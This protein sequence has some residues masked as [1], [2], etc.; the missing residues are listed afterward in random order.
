MV[1][2]GG[3]W[4]LDSYGIAEIDALAVSALFA[5][6]GFGLGFIGV[7]ERQTWWALIPA[8]VLIGIAAVTAWN[9]LTNAPGEWGAALLLISMG[10]GFFAVL[11]TDRTRWWAVIP[12]GVLATIG[13]FVGL[14]TVLPDLP[15]VGLMLF[16]FAL[17]FVLLAATPTG[18]G[19]MRWPLIPA[20]L[21]AVVGTV[22]VVGA[23]PMFEPFDDYVLPFVLLVGGLVL[24]W[25]FAAERRSTPRP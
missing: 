20:A 12:G 21:L 24:I 17:T 18:R 1:L 15:A 2:A 10:A 8:G 11:L 4:L 7:R 13:V 3:L 19:R 23:A 22:F 6:S 9:R 14:T 25:R 5:I 16:G